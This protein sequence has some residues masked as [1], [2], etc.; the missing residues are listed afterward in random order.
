[1]TERVNRLIF[2]LCLIAFLFLEWDLAVLA[3]PTILLFEAMTNLR[4]PRLISRLH[5]ATEGTN[6]YIDENENL[7]CKFEFEAERALRYSLSFIICMG[8]IFFDQTLWFLP[9]II[10]LNLLLAGITGICPLLMLFRKAGFK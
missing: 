8:F 6:T 7:Q 4:I 3:I 9:Y 1:M 5:Y 2:G 10:G